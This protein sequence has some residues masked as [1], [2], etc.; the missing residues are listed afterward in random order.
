[1]SSKMDVS[2]DD[3]N[4]NSEMAKAF[5]DNPS[6]NSD[7]SILVLGISVCLS[8]ER[9]NE[10]NRSALIRR[11]GFFSLI[12]HSKEI[13]TASSRGHFLAIQTKETGVLRN[14]Q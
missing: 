4:D 11:T 5:L 8:N 13:Q 2:T 6:Y 3:T 1:M 7:Q 12:G 9:M 14:Y 10:S